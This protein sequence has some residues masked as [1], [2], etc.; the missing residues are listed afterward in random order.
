ML[1][2]VDEVKRSDAVHM[3]HMLEVVPR[4]GTGTAT[5]LAQRTC[6][7]AVNLQYSTMCSACPRHIHVLFHTMRLKA[8]VSHS[9]A[10]LT[11]CSRPNSLEQDHMNKS[12]AQTT[13]SSLFRQP[14]AQEC[15]LQTLRPTFKCMNSKQNSSPTRVL[16]Y[17]PVADVASPWMGSSEQCLATR[18]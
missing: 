11:Y 17:C 5:H 6:N 16:Q 18:A 9:S 14:I 7:M 13:C 3:G 2:C 4:V 15:I 1:D 10:S 12:F 8:H